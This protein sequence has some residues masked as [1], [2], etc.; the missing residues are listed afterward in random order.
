[1]KS[2][3]DQGAVKAV[4][5]RGKRRPI[6]F[7]SMNKPDYE[8]AA[9]LLAPLVLDRLKREALQAASGGDRRNGVEGED[10]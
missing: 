8:L 10:A 2:K 7:T 3:E 5:T 6:I 1:M 4:K 9:T